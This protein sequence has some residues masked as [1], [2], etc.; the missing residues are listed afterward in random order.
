MSFAVVLTEDAVRDL[1]DRY[2]FIAAQDGRD[3]A[4][5]VL[6]RIHDKLATLR[7]FPERGEFPPELAA[8]GIRQF[9][10]IHYKPWRMVYQVS[11]ETVTVMLLA[12]GR[13]DMQTRLQRRLLG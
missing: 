1:D 12:D 8:L 11:A 2:S 9:R 7:D 6:G 10:Q 5:Q 13:Q 4:D 3:R